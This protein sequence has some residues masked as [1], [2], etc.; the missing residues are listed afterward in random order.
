MARVFSFTNLLIF[1]NKQEDHVILHLVRFHVHV[2]RLRVEFIEDCLMKLFMATLEDKAKVWSK[3]LPE[4]SLCSLKDLHNVFSN[5]Y[6]KSY[7]SLER[8]CDYSEGFIEYLESINDIKCMDDEEIIEAFSYF[9][10][11]QQ[12]KEASHFVHNIIV[13]IQ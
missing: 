10:L 1:K 13:S 8:C 2:C 12:S 3:R 11:Q 9:S 6:V 4:R 5:H 7:I